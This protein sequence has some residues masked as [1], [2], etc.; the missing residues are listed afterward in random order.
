MALMYKTLGGHYWNPPQDI[1]ECP[2]GAKTS[3]S[4]P[5]TAEDVTESI[6]QNAQQFQLA[7]E[8]LKSVF[9]VEVFK[10]L[11]GFGTWWC[12]FLY[13][14]TTSM[15]LVYQSYFSNL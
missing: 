7:L 13:F 4:D 14:A 15:G 12:C 3:T 8:N 6:T 11:L 9:T 2:L 10:G 5:F 1:D